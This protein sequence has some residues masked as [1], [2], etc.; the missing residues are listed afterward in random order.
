MGNFSSPEYER[1]L[2]RLA[3]NSG[4]QLTFRVCVS[5][6]ELVSLLRARPWFCGATSP[7]S[8]TPFGPAPLEANAC[9]TPVVGI[10]E[11]GIRETIKHEQNGLLVNGD[12][13]KELAQAIERLIDNPAFA[14]QLRASSLS[15]V[16]ANWRM[17]D[18]NDRVEAALFEVKQGDSLTAARDAIPPELMAGV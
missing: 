12:N 10:A 15:Y 4:V 9:G 5:H 1:E 7:D 2:Q 8:G 18:A 17:K 13:P 3:E 16:K 11:G 14:A 6:V